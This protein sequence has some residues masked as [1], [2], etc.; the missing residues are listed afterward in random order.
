MEE[1]QENANVNKKTLKLIVLNILFIILVVSIIRVFFAQAFNIPSGSMKPTLLIGD[2]ILV[3]KLVYGDWSFGIPFTNV[4][5]FTYKNRMTR[6]DRGDII[7]FRY[8][9]NPKIDFIK[10]VIGLPGDTIE[11]KNDIVYLNGK[12]IK[13]VPAGKFNDNGSYVN[14]YYEYIPRS[15]GKIYRYKVMEIIDGEGKNFGPV[16]VPEN[17]Y[18]VLGDN[19]DNSRD[20]RFWG[21]V[22]DDYLIG[23][24]FVI[25]FSVKKG[26][27]NFIRWSRIGK[28]LFEPP[29]PPDK[30][31]LQK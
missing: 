15:N 3:N 14:T 19:R 2:F 27:L 6:P 4:T 29:V 17:H 11:V 26:S 18:F 7:V 28:V 1:K 9:E 5:F 12:P 21:F 25:Y 30:L 10:R 23:Q 13:R 24:A 31:N 16:K 8:P 22:P 20:S